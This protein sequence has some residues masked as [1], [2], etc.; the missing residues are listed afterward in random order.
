VIGTGLQDLSGQ[1]LPAA[2]SQTITV[3]TPDSQALYETPN[4][5]ETTVTTIGNAFGFQGHAKDLESGLIYMRN[6]YY[7]PEMGRFV[8]A[9]PLGYSDGPSPY[10]LEGNDPA[11]GA[12]PLGLRTTLEVGR[13]RLE[14]DADLDP[15]LVKKFQAELAIRL[16]AAQ[17]AREAL[18]SMASSP[19]ESWVKRLWYA[20][21]LPWENLSVIRDEGWSG[22]LKQREFLVEE[23]RRL[24]REEWQ[25]IPGIRTIVAADQVEDQSTDFARNMQAGRATVSAG[26]DLLLVLGLRSLRGA[27]EGLLGAERVAR[28]APRLS[29]DEDLLALYARKVPTESDGFL[30][31][32]THADANSAWV[33]RDGR[34]TAVSHR[35]LARYIRG[36]QEFYG[37]SIRLLGCNAG[38]YSTGL[39]Q[40]LAN[41]LGVR[42]EAGTSNV[43]VYPNGSFSAQ[44]WRTFTPGN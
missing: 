38:S 25:A 16:G 11:N 20:A 9:D 3:T 33:L 28:A 2:L 4:P 41:K 42:V 14:L 43:L 5:R 24:A 13:F 7:D 32:V 18:E 44:G 12:D 34:W 30:N 40:N 17:R 31:V 39:A 22:F 21:T 27:G 15:A 19:I 8:S 29:A 36:L 6:R 26:E 37:Q 10:G 23:Y 35:S 1:A